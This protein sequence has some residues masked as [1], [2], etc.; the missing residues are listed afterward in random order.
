ML[1]RAAKAIGS[2]GASDPPASTTSHSPERMSRS[3]SWNAMIPDAHAATCVITGP[4]RRYRI[5]TCAAAIEPDR[6]GI[7]NG[8]T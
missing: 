5:D 7:A 6:A 1:P 4:V 2:S 3:A 8:L